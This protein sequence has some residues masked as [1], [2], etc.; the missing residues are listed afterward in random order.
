M[1]KRSDLRERLG[2]R[3]FGSRYANSVL[4]SSASGYHPP[5]VVVPVQKLVEEGGLR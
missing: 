3:R 2:N 1:Y 4:I 5:I